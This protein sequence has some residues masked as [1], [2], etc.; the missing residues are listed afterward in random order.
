M[1]NDLD[2][3]LFPDW[4]DAEKGSLNLPQFIVDL[5]RVEWAL[6]KI[7]QHTA[8]TKPNLDILTVNPNLNLVPVSHQNL[9]ALMDQEKSH[10]AIEVQA[11]EG[12]HIIIWPDPK[13][14]Q[15]QIRE[16][17]DDDLLA[18]KIVVE[19]I[20]TQ[21]AASVG[22]VTPGAI[23]AVIHRA[24]MQGILLSPK[25]L[26]RRDYPL[27]D[28]VSPDHE[29]FR[30]ADIFT[31]QWHITQACD[32]HCKHCYDRSD[33][34]PLPY[35]TALAILDD[36]H[37]FCHA[38]HVKGQVT[39]TGGNPLLYPNFSDIYRE[40]FEH[41]FG[42]AILGNPSPM[43]QIEKLLDI[44]K[45]AFF[46]ISLEGLEAHND[47]IRGTG[48][49]QRSLVFLDQLR[50]HGIYTMVMLTLSRDNLN[51]VLPLA[52]ILRD[53]T[54]FFTFNR[55]STVGEG[56]QL[57]MA[58]PED[59]QAFLKK[60]EDESHQNPVVGLK[61]NLFNIIR[62]QKDQDPFGGCTGY[63]CGAAFNFVALLADGE[64]HACRKFPSPIGNIRE[65]R[66]FDIYHSEIAQK[67]RNGSTACH[68][69]SL[70]IVCRGCPAITHSYGL[71]VFNDKDPFCFKT[72]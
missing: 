48:H 54:D 40:T 58:K 65:S 44:K 10:E 30:S 70:N 23:E 11:S 49:F 45:P 62:R 41:G 42:I 39:F 3:R 33:R 24:I 6:H 43:H 26:I 72:P 51:Q 46:Q 35:D 21:E 16:A 8:P 47:K 4:L 18:L 55:L 20:N 13:T 27:P 25:S 50:E 19:G 69:C 7:K 2:P 52:N 67:Y 14:G 56:A 32:L 64:V 28:A 34:P 57:F 63:G 12:M 31:L 68:D 29:E 1:D 5:A 66:L 71:N 61:D 60:Y 22:G 36:F 59:F 15:T 53:R 37:D 9:V 17:N 38:M